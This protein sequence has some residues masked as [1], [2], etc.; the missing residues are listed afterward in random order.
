MALQYAKKGTT[1]LNTYNAAVKNAINTLKS[2]GL[3]ENDLKSETKGISTSGAP[4][5]D[6]TE[7]EREKNLRRK[8][9]EKKKFL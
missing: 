4:Q 9:K 8:G 2:H 3:T 6:L 5:V 7:E 1:E